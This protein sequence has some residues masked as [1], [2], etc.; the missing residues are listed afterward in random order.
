M[1]SYR[2]PVDHPVVYRA[3][4]KFDGYLPILGIG[5]GKAT[6]HGLFEVAGKS[7]NTAAVKLT[8]FSV[9]FNGE[10]IPIDLD[11]AQKYVP[12]GTFTFEPNG[13]VSRWDS[14]TPTAPIRVPGLDLKH[15]PEVLFLPVAF[16]RDGV[17]AGKSFT[18][19]LPLSG[20]TSDYTVTPGAGDADSVPVSFTVHQTYTNFEDDA[21]QV[22]AEKDAAL[23]VSTEVV[24][25][26]TGVFSIKAGRFTKYSV[27]DVATSVA[28]DVQSKKATTRKLSRTLTVT[29]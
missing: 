28:T 11:D 22:V 21:N 7:D 5:Q 16:P 18:F 25:N 27:S 15:L 24:G 20:G 8:D 29:S 17:E 9:T 4:M 26:G 3:D 13:Q 10:K 19:T 14:P 6:V 1:P 12:G 2:F 23:K